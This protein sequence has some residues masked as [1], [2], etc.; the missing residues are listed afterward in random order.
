MH[1][2]CPYCQSSKVITL[3]YGRKVGGTVGTIAGA[4][5]ALPRTL[6]AVEAGLIASTIAGPPGFVV[7]TLAGY[8]LSGLVG[9]YIGNAT[10]TALGEVIDDNILD[11]YRCLGCHRKFSAPF[12]QQP[13]QDDSGYGGFHEEDE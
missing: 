2:H 9:G 3:D 7:G 10:G 1:I 8:V 11:N 6:I 12:R 13:H 4:A 5:T